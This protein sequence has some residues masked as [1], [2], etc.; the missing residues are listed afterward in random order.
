MFWFGFL[1]SNLSCLLLQELLVSFTRKNPSLFH[2]EGLTP[3]WHFC[4]YCNYF[5]C[6]NV[7]DIRNSTVAAGNITMWCFTFIQEK[8]LTAPYRDSAPFTLSIKM[9]LIVFS[10]RFST[11]QDWLK[12]GFYVPKVS[13]W[14]KMQTYVVCSKTGFSCDKQ[15][16]NTWESEAKCIETMQTNSWFRPK[17]YKKKNLKL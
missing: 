16:Q 10:F 5:D 6:W 4:N 9:R 15:L 12:S 13:R 14:K 1:A 2:W 17:T 7:T 11:G 8:T 3:T